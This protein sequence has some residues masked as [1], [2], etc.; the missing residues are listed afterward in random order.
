MA[1]LSIALDRSRKTPLADQIYRAIREAIETGKFASGARLPS[2][3]DLASQLGV[4]RGTVYNKMKK[5]A[6]N[7]EE[8]RKSELIG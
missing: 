7:P 1:S 6:I 5:F 4:S 8:F 2:W 3:R